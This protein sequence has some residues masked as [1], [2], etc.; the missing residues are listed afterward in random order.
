M[1]VFVAG[2]D[3]LSPD[4][5]LL[6]L[7]EKIA[8]VCKHAGVSILITSLTDFAAFGIGG[9]TVYNLRTFHI[10]RSKNLILTSSQKNG[11]VQIIN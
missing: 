2:W 1:F 11:F 10:L 4:E 9:I 6:P 8:I 5:K 7:N 3:N